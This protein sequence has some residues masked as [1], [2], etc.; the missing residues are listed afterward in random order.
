MATESTKD[1]VI[2]VPEGQTAPTITETGSG[3]TA[4]FTAPTAGAE[5]K[6]SG[7]L[8]VSG[9]PVT[10]SKFTFT[11]SGKV[12]FTNVIKGSKVNATSGQDS[13][14]FS[15]GKIK[16]TKVKLGDGSDSV[17]FGTQSKGAKVD[18]GN[19]NAADVVN[20]ESLK[21][22]KKMT[23]KNFGTNDTLIVGGKEFGFDD[24]QDREFK[25]I[26]IKFD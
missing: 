18:M 3:T 2:V 20:I 16:D 6:V 11:E 23:I 22:V 13:V 5:V 10:N 15:D 12:D 9:G 19:D 17:V 4:V 1:A 7:N 24:L 21:D 14:T 25:N 26:N 8:V